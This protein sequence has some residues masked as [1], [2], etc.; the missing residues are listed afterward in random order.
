MYD[1]MR[2]SFEQAGFTEEKCR[3]TLFD[4]TE[5][6]RHEPYAAINAALDEGDE[7]YLVFCHQDV[8]ADRG[9]GYQELLAAIRSLD[10]ER[11]EWAVAGNAG[12]AP[13]FGIV[14]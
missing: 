11:P 7:P 14:A 8:R 5:G 12:V 6:N 13:D 4:N 9:D 10:S 2:E 3:Y 1:E